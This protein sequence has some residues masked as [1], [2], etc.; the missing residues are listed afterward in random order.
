MQLDGLG[1]GRLVDGGDGQ[2]RLAL[3]DGLVGER[4]FGAAAAGGGGGGLPAAAPAAGG[5]TGKSLARRIA[6]H[7][8]MRERGAVVDADAR[9]RAAS[10]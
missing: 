10:G 6:L 4:D 9:A 3:V 8:G 1:R 2:D 5:G 7:A